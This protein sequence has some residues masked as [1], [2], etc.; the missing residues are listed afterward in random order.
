MELKIITA[1]CLKT[2]FDST[3]GK[4]IL[5]Q[6]K[7]IPEFQNNFRS[8]FKVNNINYPIVEMGRVL[9]QPDRGSDHGK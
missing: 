5:L 8:K 9:R 3:I 6:G 1:G 4:K 2:T 7:C